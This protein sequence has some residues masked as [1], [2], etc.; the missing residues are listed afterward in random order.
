MVGCLIFSSLLKFPLYQVTDIFVGLLQFNKIVLVTNPILS[1]I[2]DVGIKCYAKNRIRY[3]LIKQIILK[4]FNNIICTKFGSRSIENTFWSTNIKFKCIIAD[5]LS[6]GWNRFLGNKFAI[7]VS[8][9]LL[10]K[11]FKT[12]I[13]LWKIK[14]LNKQKW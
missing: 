11:E 13:K 4:D 2:F 7:R 12:N 1:R 3:K 9:N 6:R 14:I 5:K 10:I 8:N